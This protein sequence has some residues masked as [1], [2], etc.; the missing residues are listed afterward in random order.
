MISQR[1]VQRFLVF[2]KRVNDSPGGQVA[3]FYMLIGVRSDLTSAVQGAL[4]QFPVFFFQAACVYQRKKSHF[5]A[6]LPAKFHVLPDVIRGALVAVVH[7]NGNLFAFTVSV[8]HDKFRQEFFASAL[9]NAQDREQQKQ[10]QQERQASFQHLS[11]SVF[12]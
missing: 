6:I 12:P 2:P 1:P 10:A 5:D 11:S 9:R 7:R 4:P 3:E 8:V